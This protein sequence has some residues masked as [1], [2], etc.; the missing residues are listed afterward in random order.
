MAKYAVVV[1]FPYGILVHLSQ[2]GTGNPFFYVF[3]FSFWSSF[4]WLE[5]YHSLFIPLTFFHCFFIPVFPSCGIFIFLSFASKMVLGP[6]ELP[7][8]AF[9]R[10]FF[11]SLHFV[12]CLYRYGYFSFLW[13]ENCPWKL[14]KRNPFRFVFFPAV[15]FV[16]FFIV[17][18]IFFFFR[19]FYLIVYFFFAFL[20]HFIFHFHFFCV[21]FHLCFCFHFFVLVQV[22]VFF[23]IFAVV[24]FLVFI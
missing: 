9:S 1:P 12:S 21:C 24:S 23:F 18:F 11:V 16:S 5:N 10:T 22:C 2:P 14:S 7:Q 6:L 17:V 20:F 13:F 3:F 4:F 19:C 8:G 15:F